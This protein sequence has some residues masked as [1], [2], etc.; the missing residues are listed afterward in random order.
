MIGAAKFKKLFAL[1]MV[2]TL[3][4]PA[5]ALGETAYAGTIKIGVYEPASGDNGAGGKQETLGVEYANFVAPSVTLSDGEYKVELVHADN[6][7]ST[8]KAPSAAQT[9]VSADVSVV[10]GSYGS[11]VSI[12]AADIFD[13]AGLVAVGLSCTN[14]Q[15]TLGNPLYYR[16]CYLDPFQGTVLASFALEEYGAK[17]AYTLAMLGEDYGVGLVNYFTEA[18]KAAGGEVDGET[19]PEGTSDFTAYLTTAFNNGAEVIFAPTS[20]PY[21]AQIITQAAS[22]GITIPILAGDTW[23][24]SVIVEAAK[25]TD[26]KVSVSTF[27]DEGDT[28][29]KAVEFVTGFKAWL[30]ANPDKLVN[31]GGNDGIAGVTPLGYDGYMVALEAIKAADSA[32]RDDIADVMA[33]ITYDGVTGAI[34][35]DE[36]GDAIRDQAFIKA[37]E[38]VAGTW[39]FV[40]VQGI[41]K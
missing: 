35:F 22:N 31:N 26:V 25:T 11:S 32:D 17:K 41:I 5:F 8:D 37:T 24:N 28:S 16:V 9:L 19:F 36:N 34:V 29:P 7:S 12:A 4:L 14:P 2:L 13:Q 30:N 15:V 10:L 39:T 33:G 40:K 1:L 21:A 18:F 20:T 3:M 6:Q 38:N 23:D 27:F